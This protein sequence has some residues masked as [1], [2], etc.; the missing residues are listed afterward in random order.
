MAR[1]DVYANIGDRA[2]ST[3]YL[4]NV[5]S[6]LLSDLES[7][8]VIPLRRVDFFPRVKIAAQLTPVIL[9]DGEQ[10]L[11]ETPKMAAVPRRILGVPVLSLAAEHERITAAMDF[12]FQGF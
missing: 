7:C 6:D 3:P 9:I 1:F 8:V 2:G 12:L 11:L 4:V 5:Q 10:F